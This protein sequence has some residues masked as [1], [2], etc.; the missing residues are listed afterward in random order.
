M[1][2][3]ADWIVN[4]GEFDKKIRVP[5]AWGQDVDVRWEGPATYVREFDLGAPNVLRFDGVSYAARVFIND[6]LVAEHRGIWDAFEVPLPAGKSLVRVEVTKN[7]GPTFP[8]KEVLS[9]FLPYVFHTFGGIWG[10]VWLTDGEPLLNPVAASRLEVRGNQ[11]WLDGERFYMRGVLHW[12]WYPEF[13]HPHGGDLIAKEIEIAQ[14]QGFNIFKF[15]LWLPP[16]EFLDQLEQAGMQAWIELP[17]WA[18][19]DWFD[20]ATAMEELRRIVQQYRHHPNLIAWTAGCEL[21]KSVS[22][23][24][25]LALVR[26]IQ[27]ETG[28][29]LVKDNSGGSEMY[30]ADLREFG[31]FNDYHPYADA[32]WYPPLL[33]SLAN[34]PRPL[35]PIL[36]GEFNDHDVHRDLAQIK[37][38]TPYWASSDPS[39]NDQGSRWQY[40]LPIFLPHWRWTTERHTQLMESSRQKSLF[41]RRFVHDFVRQMPDIA[42][43]VITGWRD[44]PISSSGMVDDWLQ[45]RFSP[46]EC[47][48][49]NAEDAY[50]VIPNRCPPWVNGGNRPGWRSLYAGFTGWNTWKLGMAGATGSGDFIEAS[51]SGETHQFPRRKDSDPGWLGEISGSLDAGIHVLKFAHRHL[52]ILIADRWDGPIPSAETALT[53]MPFFRECIQEFHADPLWDQLGWT[54]TWEFWLDVAPDGAMEIAWLNE[55]NPG[56]QPVLTRIDTRTYAEHVYIAKTD[57]GYVHCLRL[58]GGHGIQPLGCVNNPVANA[59]AKAMAT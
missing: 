33:E 59:I 3:V 42:G 28:A 51:L 53:P 13:G 36:L 24:F 46:E 11:L 41:V 12:G 35:L 50:F 27:E 45:P 19:A 58:E 7:G 48:S 26:M 56:W 52:P 5:H 23:E 2:E 6:Q 38:E 1:R 8:V 55:H 9:G 17:L 25:R 30:G 47:Q 20:E 21:G 34:G 4:Y 54:D 31:T 29:A 22:P 16:H 57:A 32:H 39:L 44:T 40:D 14:A 18:P 15:C 43:Y 37:E 10:R 49:W